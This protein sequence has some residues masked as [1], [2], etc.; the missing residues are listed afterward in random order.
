[1]VFNIIG[2]TKGVCINRPCV[3]NTSSCGHKTPVCYEKIGNI[4]AL[5]IAIEHVFFRIVTKT[6]A[7]RLEILRR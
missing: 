1:M 6:A 5:A 3:R 2:D 7:S 4:V